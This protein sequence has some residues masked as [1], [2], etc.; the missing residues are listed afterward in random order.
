VRRDTIDTLGHDLDGLFSMLHGQERETIP[1]TIGCLRNNRLPHRHSTPDLALPL[2]R[3]VGRPMRGNFLAVC[4]YGH[5]P[6]DKG[7]KARG[8][9]PN[10][11]FA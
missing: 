1:H 8:A 2:L 4:R 10:R 3:N 5:G 7:M 9:T 11:L 6:F